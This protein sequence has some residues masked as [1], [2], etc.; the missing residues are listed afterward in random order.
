VGFDLNC[1]MGEL[2]RLLADGTQAELVRYATS[3]NIC[4][5]VHAGSE[6][7]IARTLEMSRF[8]RVG[9]HPG[10][11]DRAN[12]GR[13]VV[14]MTTAALVDCIYTQLVW[15]G[16]I[17]ARFGIQRITH[18]KAHGALYN[19]AVRD[20]A[21]AGAIAEATRGWG[22][23]VLL[24]GLEGSPMLDVFRSAG[25]GVLA[26]GFADRAY[27]PDG[28]LRSRKLAGALIEDPVLA[29][30]QAVRLARSV[31]TICIHSDT[32]GSAKLA[33]AVRERL[34]AMGRMKES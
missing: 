22:R 11:P 34:D 13:E 8:L 21:I 3:V 9:A 26:E 27:E 29:A 31:D 2:E 20:A 28:T 7:L 18:V 16:E 14:P 1:D 33:K 24:V 17:A 10:Y 12:F 6:D 4:C 23:D 19:A 32:P 15:F 5:N 30:E 25:F